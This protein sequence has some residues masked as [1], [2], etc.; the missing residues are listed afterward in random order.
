MPFLPCIEFVQ[1]LS[2]IPK[3]WAQTDLSDWRV[4]S[5]HILPGCVYS[6]S[7]HV[8][9][10]RTVLAGRRHPVFQG[11]ESSPK[12]TMQWWGRREWGFTTEQNDHQH[13][14]TIVHLK[15]KWKSKLT[16]YS[17]TVDLYKAQM[18][19]EVHALLFSSFFDRGTSGPYSMRKWLDLLVGTECRGSLLRLGH[20]WLLC[21]RVGGCWAVYEQGWMLVVIKESE[22]DENLRG[23]RL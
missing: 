19:S 4:Y 23:N 15:N 10:P 12:A 14:Y 6:P 8:L 13:Q 11:V 16:A 5:W 1:A 20:F 22:E 18:L 3:L 2:V 7:E 9:S 17:W 21:R